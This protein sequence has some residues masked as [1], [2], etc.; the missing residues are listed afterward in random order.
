MRLCGHSDG[1]G[2]MEKDDV[3]GVTRV[4]LESKRFN[5]LILTPSPVRKCWNSHLISPKSSLRSQRPVTHDPVTRGQ[6]SLV[7]TDAELILG[8][9]SGRCIIPHLHHPA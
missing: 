2:W 6:L 8:R 5:N 9:D 4:V 7:I 3:G 1:Y